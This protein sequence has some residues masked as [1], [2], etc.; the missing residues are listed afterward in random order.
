[1][2]D[3]SLPEPLVRERVPP[4]CSE[5]LALPRPHHGAPERIAQAWRP[6]AR[7]LGSVV[8]RQAFVCGDGAAN[9]ALLD[10][11]VAAGVP[12]TKDRL[13]SFFNM[14]KK[15]ENALSR[16]RP[17]VNGLSWAMPVPPRDPKGHRTGYTTG[18][19]A[20]AAA[21]AAARC[22]V[23][24]AMLTEIET[25]LP[26]NARPFALERCERTGERATCS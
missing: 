25:T 9:Y 12:A 2:P 15:S 16:S 22:L 20:A 7:V 14:P 13:E 4:A 24:D 1:M 21:K 18:A 19:C 8:I 23:G 26:N 11:L 6:L 3:Y 10:D 5:L 17:T